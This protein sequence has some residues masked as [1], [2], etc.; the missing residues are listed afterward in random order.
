M[1]RDTIQ[2]VDWHTG[3]KEPARVVIAGPGL[4]RERLAPVRERIGME[5][6]PFHSKMRRCCSTTKIR[7][8]GVS[9]N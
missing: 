5:L 4:G 7:S 3:G 6:D 1:A 8:A 9:G 2:V